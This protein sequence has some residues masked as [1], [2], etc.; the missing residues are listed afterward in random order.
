MKSGIISEI[1]GTLIHAIDNAS[2][3]LNDAESCVIDEDKYLESEG[4]NG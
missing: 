3:Y 2:E 4:K 1:I